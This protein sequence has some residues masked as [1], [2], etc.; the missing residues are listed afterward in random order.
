MPALALRYHTQLNRVVH[1]AIRIGLADVGSA[2]ANQAEQFRRSRDWDVVK[3]MAMSN[4]NGDVLL[5]KKS[6][7][8]PQAA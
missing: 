1:Y 5:W 2:K 8:S 4:V 7:I 3:E 6:R